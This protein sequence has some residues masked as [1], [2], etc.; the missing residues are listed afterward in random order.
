MTVKELNEKLAV[1]I[2]QGHANTRV[3]ANCNF[4]ICDKIY[5]NYFED[6]YICNLTDVYYQSGDIEMKF[7]DEVKE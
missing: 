2:E 6:F 5:G 4:K 7:I 1:L 3:I